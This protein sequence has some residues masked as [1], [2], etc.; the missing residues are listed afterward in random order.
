MVTGLEAQWE[1]EPRVQ[2]KALTTHL[3][4]WFSQW[5]TGVLP[6]L[7]PDQYHPGITQAS[8]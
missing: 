1:A 6:A 4:V 5:E 3:K 8:S 2:K 7:S